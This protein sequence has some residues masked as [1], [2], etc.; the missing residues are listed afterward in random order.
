MNNKGIRPS[1]LMTLVS[2]AAVMCQGCSIKEDR[3]LCPCSFDLDFSQ[4]ER[5]VAEMTEVSVKAADGF[6]YY[7]PEA[8]EGIVEESRDGV[9]SLLYNIKV[10]K[11]SLEVTVV[12]GADGLFS[13]DSGILIPLG[14]ECPPVYMHYSEVNAFSEQHTEEV[15][16][17]KDYCRIRINMLTSDKDYPFRL[18]VRGN[19]CGIRP[20]RS[21]V[22]G[23]FSFGFTLDDTGQGEVRVPRQTDNSLILQILEDET[24]LREFALGEYIAE[25]GYSWTDENLEDIEVSIDYAHSDISIN[26]ESWA[27]SFEFDV[28]I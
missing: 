24:V 9:P 28:V 16:L 5:Q 2:V 3:S 15:R 11:E 23:D 17:G 26:V 6:L 8:G 22:P 1:V 25:T 20:D 10:P 14:D 7:D 4:V 12:Y 13:P 27:G 18:T 19:V 21:V